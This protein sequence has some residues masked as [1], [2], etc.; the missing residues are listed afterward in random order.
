MS[1]RTPTAKPLHP[2]PYKVT[3]THQEPIAAAAYPDAELDAY[4]YED[5]DPDADTDLDTDPYPDPHEWP[6]ADPYPYADL[7]VEQVY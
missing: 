7:G 5:A 3:Y 1:C 6:D 4:S 2:N